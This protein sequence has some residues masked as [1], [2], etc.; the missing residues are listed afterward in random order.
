MRDYDKR[1]IVIKDYNSIFMFLVAMPWLISSFYFLFTHHNKAAFSFLI[2]QTFYFN[3][4]PYIF[5]GRK[6]SVKLS[7]NKIEFLQADNIIESINL[8]EKFEIYKTF[9]DYYHKSQNLSNLQK[10]VKWISV[11]L[12]WIAYYPFFLLSKILFYF[13]KTKG[14]FYKFYDCIIIFQDDKVLNIL[15]T[16]RF[17]RALVKKYFLDKFKIDIDLLQV[18]KKTDHGLEK[19]E[20]HKIKSQYMNTILSHN[21]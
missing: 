3:I 12:L 14:T 8:D 2:A 15:A 13:F 9:D 17:E 1:P 19:I 5:S 6:R 18:C 10:K 11:V 21:N 7:N 4:R 16:S 20:M